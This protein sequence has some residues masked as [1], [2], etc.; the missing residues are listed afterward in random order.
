MELEEIVIKYK[1][2]EERLKALLI[3]RE[4]SILLKNEIEN[5]K[6]CLEEIKNGNKIKYIS[7]GADT[8][9]EIES[10]KNDYVIINVGSNILKKFK[11]EDAI[12][13]LENEKN[14]IDKYIEFLNQLQV[15][16]EK[17]L[18]VLAEEIKKVKNLKG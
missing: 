13:F 3:E 9:I 15:E 10:F 4:K 17:D 14:E 18:K 12:N 16:T 2:L 8:F 11:I 5:V 7:I 1:Q 6:K